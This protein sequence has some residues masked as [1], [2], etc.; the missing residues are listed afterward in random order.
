MDKK[1]EYEELEI[2][3]VEY[4]EEDIITSS[5]LCDNELEWD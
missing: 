4:E 5:G 2:E 1:F 3:V